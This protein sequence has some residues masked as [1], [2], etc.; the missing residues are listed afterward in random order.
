LGR[1]GIFLTK[2]ADQIPKNLPD[3]VRHFGFVPLS[4][5]LRRSAAFVHHGGI[6]SSSQ[7][8]QAGIPQIVRPMAFD[9]FDNA[10]RVRRLGVGKELW[11]RQ[12]NVRNLTRA[13][14]YLLTSP[15]VAARCQEFA[16]RCDGSAALTAA[17]DALERIAPEAVKSST[18]DVPAYI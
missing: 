15:E 3:T 5:L 1:R 14:D 17:C 12:F 7:A 9:Q 13:L 16:P 2:Y 8:I 11:P 18:A 6:G 4:L 10:R